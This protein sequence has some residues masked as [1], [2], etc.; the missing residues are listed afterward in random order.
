V[1]HRASGILI[2]I[3]ILTLGPLQGQTACDPA[4]F[5]AKADGTTKDT[6][7]I[8]GAID[9]CANAGGGI[10]QL[11]TGAYLSA[12]LTLKSNVTL[13]IGAGVRLLAS[14]DAAD[15][16]SSAGA[17]LRPLVGASQQTDIGIT[18]QGTIDGAGAPWW[19]AVRLV[20]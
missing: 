7:A 20:N 19:A 3:Q 11:S 8:Q 9:S 16:S 14:S 2:F 12:P 13:D 5:G 17:S 18:G 4:S 6:S 15:Y 1:L 10:V